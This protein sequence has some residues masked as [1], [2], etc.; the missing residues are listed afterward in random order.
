MSHKYEPS[1]VVLVHGAAGGVGTAVLDLAKV[2]GT[3]I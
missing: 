3:E 1:Q 2:R